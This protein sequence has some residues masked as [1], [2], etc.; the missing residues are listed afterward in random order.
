MNLGPHVGRKL[1][2]CLGRSGGTGFESC[3][4]MRR[5]STQRVTVSIPQ[6]T[7][8]EFATYMRQG[9]TDMSVDLSISRTATDRM[10]SEEQE[11]LRRLSMGV[12]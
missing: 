7:L 3:S 10:T 6:E 12:V 2:I 5:R 1:L 11:A 8:D 4:W 9:K